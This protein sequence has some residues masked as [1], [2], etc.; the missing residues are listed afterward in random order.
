[1]KGI[2]RAGH[3]L[4]WA[5]TVN[6]PHKEISVDQG[7]D[8]ALQQAVIHFESGV[9][10]D[11]GTQGDDRNLFHSCFPQCPSDKTDVIGGAA[12]ASGLCDDHGGAVK[13]VFAGQ[14]RLH[15]LAHHK[16]GRVA[17]VIVDI[18][19]SV[20]Q[21]SHTAGKLN[22]VVAAGGQGWDQHIKMNW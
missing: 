14:Q 13:I 1:M 19:Q 5:G 8:G 7:M 10:F 9:G 4:I 20:F 22:H 6:N 15:K 18:F 11:P 12:A 16:E 17:G 21:F 3:L 2:D